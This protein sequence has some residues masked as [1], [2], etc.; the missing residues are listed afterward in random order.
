[1]TAM[2]NH[3][4]REHNFEKTEQAVNSAKHPS[5]TTNEIS[6]PV[7]Q[8]KYRLH[9]QQTKYRQRAVRLVFTYSFAYVLVKTSLESLQSFHM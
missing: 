5:C 6:N 9:V 8:T 7:Q 4:I 1:M 2:N 3:S